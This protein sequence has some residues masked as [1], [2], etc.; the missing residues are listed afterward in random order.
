MSQFKRETRTRSSSQDRKWATQHKFAFCRDNTSKAAFSV[1]SRHISPQNSCRHSLSPALNR[2]M[3]GLFSTVFVP[4]QIARLFCFNQVLFAIAISLLSFPSTICSNCSSLPVRRFRSPNGFES[5]FE[6][7]TKL[8]VLLLSLQNEISFL[9][10]L[11]YL[12]LTLGPNPWSYTVC[13]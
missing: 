12:G 3:T 6:N 8:P 11:P 1:R 5:V 4:S 9:A 10:F 7:G 13:L 2:I